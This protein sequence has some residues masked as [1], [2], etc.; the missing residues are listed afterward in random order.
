MS[1]VSICILT[2]NVFF[3]NRLAVEKIREY[4]KAIDYEILFYDN[5]S[6]DGST[7]WLAEQD[8]VKIWI[9]PSNS[10]RH[11]EALDFLSRRAKYPICAFLCS[12]AFPVSPEWLTPAAMLSDE[13]YL[14]GIRRAGA[15]K[16]LCQYPCPSYMFGW[17][18]WVKRHSFVDNWPKWDTGE[19]LAQE[20]LDEG[21]KIMTWDSTVVEMDGFKPKLCDYNG[22]VWHTWWSGRKQVVKGLAG[23]E[24][25][26]GYHEYAQNLLRKRFN[27]DY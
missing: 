10:M 19:K 23:N 13:V 22:W 2:Y 15:R 1:G 7:E 21:H 16:K 12:D 6:T 9:G 17:T 14:S 27:L 3:Y 8:D 11:G 5:A 24:F 4:T 26:E 25:E 18:Q 20:C